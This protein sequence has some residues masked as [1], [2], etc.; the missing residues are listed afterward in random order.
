MTQN[1]PLS[2]LEPGSP[3]DL[4]AFVT[5]FAMFLPED[6]RMII[7]QTIAQLD[8]AGGI[9]NEAQGQ[10]ILTNLMKGLGL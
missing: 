5:Q 1:N 7:D 2:G 8:A 3:E 6:K 10:E 9:Q 4:K